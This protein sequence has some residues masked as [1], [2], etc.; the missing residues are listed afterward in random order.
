MQWYKNLS[1]FKKLIVGFSLVCIIMAGVG[2]IGVS[3][4]ARVNSMLNA[5]YE[6]ELLGISR[7]KEANVK[8]VGIRS[9]CRSVLL[10]DDAAEKSR[11]SEDAEALAKEFSSLI[12]ASKPNFTTPEGVALIKG[13]EDAFPQY[14]AGARRC[15]N[16]SLENKQSEAIAAMESGAAAADRLDS[17]LS[18]L[19]RLKE[20]LA[21][22]AYENSDEVYQT[23][24][25]TIV[26]VSIIGVIA[27]V[28][29]GTFIARLFS[30]PLHSTV[31]TLKQIALGDFTARV[32]VTTTDE[33]G[34]M[35]TSLNDALANIQAA[36]T[37]TRS[38]AD[39]VASAAQQLSAASEEI[40]SGAQEQASGLEETAASLEEITSTV[41]QNADNAQQANQLASSARETAEKGG[42]IVNDAV[43]G[44]T[45]INGASRKIA[46]I[47]TT[48][49]EIAFQTNLLALN[50]A[51]EAARAGE[52][53]RGFAV[54]AGEVRNLA[55]R[56][57]GA[58][59]EIKVLINDS[60]QKVD[61]GSNL[62]NQS[63]EA[64]D[65]IV[66]SVK[67]VTDIVSE[68]AAAS[69]EQTRGI[70]QVNKAV[71]QMD[72]VT[73][74][75]ASQT[76][77]L[78]GTAESLS[79]QAERLQELIARF[80]LDEDHAAGGRSRAGQTR[81]SPASA[82]SRTAVLTASQSK[83]AMVSVSKDDFSF[84]D[85]GDGELVGAASAN[86]GGFEEF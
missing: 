5:M 16:L 2:Y 63:G 4:A 43:H 54:V 24:R 75:N 50:A 68:I 33:I 47:I 56:S 32:K 42:Q 35:G 57:A 11:Y 77:E 45:E 55:Q 78:S 17:D 41:R 66:Q 53:G 34:E 25:T 58:A 31:K 28:L 9:T 67:R 40:S 46:D 84:D 3:R 59:K 1:A 39:S 71:S 74:A 49:D 38:V 85:P 15:M 80:K 76:E 13:I 18:E 27:G 81:K 29:I 36:L 73:Q 62:V 6:N 83:K 44:M 22:Q 64:L 14:M 51:V 37:E 72:T 69:R 86:D 30:L 12:A 70:D 20:R 48:I 10:S 52:Q 61:V 26:T 65:G 82:N 23:A 79:S 60:V 21:E 8:L 19:A 7:C